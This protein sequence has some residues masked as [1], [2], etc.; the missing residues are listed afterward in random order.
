MQPQYIINFKTYL[1]G[2]GKNALELAKICEKVAKDTGEQITIAVQPTDLL[3]IAK[4]VSIPVFAQHIDAIESGSHTGHILPEAIT[5]AG[6]KGT[7]INHSEKRMDEKEIKLCIE[8]AN[9]LG[10]TTVVCAPDPKT[11]GKLSKLRPDYIALEPPELIGTNTSVS[12]AKP[13]IIEKAVGMLDIGMPL[14][15][16]AGIKT[17]EDVQAGLKLGAKGVLVASGV[18]KA[19]D[20]EAALKELVGH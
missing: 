8:R 9:K 7:L 20:Q 17:N 16:G 10:L 13:D 18:V 4:Q 1:Q 3:Y 19:D 14:L 12:K 11:A 15:V 5:A 2:T 6:A